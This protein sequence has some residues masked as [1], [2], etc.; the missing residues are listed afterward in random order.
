MKLRSSE[1]RRQRMKPWMICY[2]FMNP[3]WLTSFSFFVSI[4]SPCL[5]IFGKPRQQKHLKTHSC[6][7]ALCY[8]IWPSESHYSQ[9]RLHKKQI[10]THLSL[11]LFHPLLSVF[12]PRIPLKLKEV[13][14]CQ[15]GERKQEHVHVSETNKVFLYL[16]LLRRSDVIGA[17]RFDVRE[18]TSEHSFYFQ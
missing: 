3:G 16:L 5:E 11:I 18:P 12:S 1:I 10:N 7:P 15:R 9:L 14:H 13:F 2:V 8:I 6:R 4:D 17:T